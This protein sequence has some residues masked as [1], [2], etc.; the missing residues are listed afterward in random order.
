MRKGAISRI[1]C[2]FILECL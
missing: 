2:I 1:I